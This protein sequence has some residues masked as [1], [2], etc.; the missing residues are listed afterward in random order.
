MATLYINHTDLPKGTE[1]EVVPFGVFEN[2]KAYEVDALDE[3]TVVGHQLEEGE[4]L[5]KRTLK[6]PKQKQLEEAA[7]LESAATDEFVAAQEAE[8]EIHP[9][10]PEP[11][12]AAAADNN[13]EESNDA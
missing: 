12:G 3:D 11:E 2:G 9:V 7:K 8:Q 5:P 4:S 13:Q 10:N 6:W 1:I